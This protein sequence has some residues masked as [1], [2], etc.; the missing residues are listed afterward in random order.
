MT[1]GTWGVALYSR[2]FSTLKALM[3][4][5]IALIT[6]T[7]THKVA[8]PREYTTQ[9][10][11]LR[12]S[13]GFL[14]ETC[15]LGTDTCVVHSHLSGNFFNHIGSQS[16]VSIWPTYP[17]CGYLYCVCFLEGML[18]ILIVL[19]THRDPSYHSTSHHQLCMAW[20]LQCSAVHVKKFL[21]VR[22][23]LSILFLVAVST[24]S[25]V[26]CVPS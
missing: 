2:D 17:Q 6:S 12:N 4:V 7:N 22:K 18:H 19:N 14:K 26:A 3:L 10:Q 5:P 1:G 11:D 20:A 25:A 13:T 16:S 24:P 21:S 15:A 8:S 9:L 23:I